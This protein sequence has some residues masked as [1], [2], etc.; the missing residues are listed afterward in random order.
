MDHKNKVKTDFHLENL[1][2]ISKSDNQKNKS[3]FKGVIYEYVD[4]IPDDSIVVNDYG[5]YKFENY[6]YCDNIFYFYNGVQYRKLH[7]NEFKNGSKYVN[8]YN[9]NN[10]KVQICYSKFKKIYDLD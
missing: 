6:Y 3:S 2:W 1:R 10:E 5:K 7:I 8:M 9:T 4:E